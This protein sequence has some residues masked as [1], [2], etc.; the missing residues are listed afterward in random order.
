[1]RTE[2]FPALNGNGPA[3]SPDP[4]LDPSQGALRAARSKPARYNGRIAAL[5]AGGAAILVVG[6]IFAPALIG[7]SAHPKPSAPTSAN[8][9]PPIPPV[10]SISYDAAPADPATG[11]GGVDC[12]QYPGMPGCAAKAAAAAAATPPAPSLAAPAGATDAPRDG[13]APG[14]QIAQPTQTSAQPGLAGGSPAVVARSSGVFFAATAGPASQGPAAAQGAP[15]TPAVAQ[16]P[17]PLPSPMTQFQPQKESGP[18]SEVMAQNGQGEKAAFIRTAAGQDYVEARLSRPRSPYEIKAGTV[19]PAALL[20]A[21]NSD[22]PGEVIAQVTQPVYDHVTGRYVLIPQGARLIGRYDAQVAYGQTRAL[23]VWHRVIFPN[24]NSLNFGNMAATDSSG[25]SGVADRV[26]DHFGQIAK[27]IALSTL[28]SMGAASAQDA[29]ARSSGTL[30]LN[31][32]VSG[33]ANEAESVG[34]RLVSRD[35]NRQPTLT[36]RPGAR[37]SVLVDKDMILEPYN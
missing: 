27:G 25:A 19:I 8:G 6:A 10:D 2:G 24:G 36:I 16:G 35:L 9:A 32:G 13:A 17:A 5:L 29:Q 20:T 28:L 12:S 33:V 15:P 14:S 11:T 31:A 18:S 26:N 4:K 23:V 7:K 37:V 22:L 3:P 34:S 1:M 21:I 30:V